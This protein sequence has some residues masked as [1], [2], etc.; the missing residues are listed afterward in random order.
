M[1]RNHRK[2]SETPFPPFDLERRRFDQFQQMTNRRGQY[3]SIAFEVVALLRKP[4]QGLGNI[5]RH[6][7]FLR[8]D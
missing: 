8:D 4:A 7:R 5:A 2:L 3:V 6:G 1:V